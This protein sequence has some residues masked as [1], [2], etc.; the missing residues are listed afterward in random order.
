MRNRLAAR[1][2]L[3]EALEIRPGV[4][5]HLATQ[6]GPLAV[7][8]LETTGLHPDQGDEILEIGIVQV[9]PG[10]EALTTLESLVHP[11]GAIPW[12]VSRLTGLKAEDVQDAPP[13]TELLEEL[14]EALQDRTWVAHNAVFEERFLSLLGVPELAPRALLDTLDLLAITHPDAPDLRLETFTRKLLHREER[15]RALSDALDTACVMAHIG[16]EAAG[17][18]PRYQGTQRALGRYAPQSPW[19]HLFTAPRQAGA[20]G[21][22]PRPAAVGPSVFVSID[23]SDEREESV[24]PFNEEA[25]AAALQDEARG[26]RHFEGY[27]VRKEQVE[28]AR[29]FVRNLD[30]EEVL[31]AEGGT[32]VGKSL[33][34]LSAAIPYAMQHREPE[35]DAPLVIATRTKFLQD[36]LMEQDIP[37]AA[38]M[39]GYPGLRAVSIKGRANYACAR[40]LALV[41][42]EGGQESIFPEDR[43]AYAVLDAC[44]R[45]RSHGEIGAVPAVLH[46]RYKELGGLLRRAVSSRSEQCTRE[47]CSKQGDCPLGRMREALPKAHLIIT[48]HDLLLRWPPDYPRFEHA[49]VDEAHELSGVADEVYADLVEPG[50]VLECFDEIFGRPPARG[51]SQGPS[52]LTRKQLEGL[53][54]SRRAWRRD[55]QNRFSEAGRLL[56]DVSGEYGEVEVPDPGNTRWK[57]VRRAL[58]EIAARLVEISRAAALAATDKENTALQG[59]CKELGTAA[60]LLERAFARDEELETV[61]SF[62]NVTE[63]HDRWRLVMRQVSPADSF[64]EHFM[65][66]ELRSFAAVS[67]SLFVNGDGFA[68]FGDLELE[69]RAGER[70]FRVSALSPFNYRDHMRVIALQGVQVENL[71]EAT[72]QVLEAAARVLRGR[73]LGLFTSVKRMQEV[74]DNLAS[75]L[76]ESGIDI[77]VPRGAGDD[78]GALVAR[79][80]R[81]TSILLGA[82]RFWQG[83]DIPGDALQVVVI[84]KLPFEVPTDL[85]RRRERK[86]EEQGHSPFQR[87]G[88]NRM[89]LNLKQMVGRLIRSEGDR[90]VVVIVDGRTDK[91]YFRRLAGA[92]PPGS[93]PV[94]VGR[95]AETRQGPGLVLNSAAGGA[96]AGA[97]GRAAGAPPGDALESL[98]VEVGVEADEDAE[99]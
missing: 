18:N 43:L 54:A 91:N 30:R 40:R 51:R 3:P 19:R 47:Q 20:A 98:L 72:T 86:I 15:H 8:D 83:V 32:G 73:T 44:A 82:R 63:R 53:E 70:L 66:D 67:A 69:E 92:L 62:E 26:R 23:K 17:G 38:R 78:P 55:L 24:V 22:K 13:I 1:T 52:L 21:K 64:H 65:K 97:A 85:R 48:N 28:L 76:S 94:L 89:L 25:V 57:E 10:R 56:L 9:E 49:I 68:A 11:K 58:A 79:F 95:L 34:Y 4:L 36:Q 50:A 35:N 88:L 75:R 99:G 16:A 81:G 45:L 42:A 41:L 2:A 37:A 59:A 60:G 5:A 33:A 90:G 27:R 77:L 96:K 61:T 31:L 7:V 6:L 71:V 84:E 12:A 29:G 74:G 93:A 80:E 87:Y 46:R 39:L 14:V